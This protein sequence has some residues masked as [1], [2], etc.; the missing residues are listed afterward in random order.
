LK[1]EKI[2]E[3]K[4]LKWKFVM[5]GKNL[6]LKFE[7][8]KKIWLKWKNL[9]NEKLKQNFKKWNLNEKFN[10]RIWNVRILE[11]KI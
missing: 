5:K 7:N 1:N 4:N 8:E 2:F 10:E 11:W 3:L 9:K 6:K